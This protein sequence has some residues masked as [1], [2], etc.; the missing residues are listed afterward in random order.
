MKKTSLND[1]ASAL[2]V[3]ETLVS[4]VLNGHGDKKKI[5]K[6]TQQKVLETARKLNYQPN[7]LARGLRTGKTHVIGLIV[8]DISNIFY[9]KI[10]REIEKNALLHNYTVIFCS[11]D[12]NPETEIKLIKMLQNKQV[13]GMII[14]TCQKNAS[15]FRELRASKMPFVL[16]DRK[17]PRFQANYVGS[18][19][20]SGAFQATNQLI[21][22]GFKKIALLK[23]TPSHISTMIE[24][25]SGFRTAMSESKLRI[26]S[27]LVANIRHDHLDEDVKETLKIWCK[28]AHTIDAIFSLNN[29][30]TTSCLKILNEDYS[31]KLKQISIFS[32]DD[33]ELFNLSQIPV[34][35]IRQS[36]E[37]IGKE[38]VKTLI[39]NINQTDKEFSQM[40]LPVEIKQRNKS[41]INNYKSKSNV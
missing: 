32:F 38:S 35:S 41:K 2:N 26:S 21:K 10:A 12:E 3:S 5:G 1:I 18:D 6:E 7:L 29:S 17:L 8:T 23:I 11:S 24:R 14:S 15:I 34:S 28:E 40:V 19:N 33:I 25:E 31:D 27:Q 30:I 9:A 22:N 37:E 20:Y 36:I 16:M 39:D 13:D 4:F